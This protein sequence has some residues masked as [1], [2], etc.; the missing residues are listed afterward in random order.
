M[1]AKG[2]SLWGRPS[3]GDEGPP[4]RKVKKKLIIFLLVFVLNF[5][6][7]FMFH[8]AFFWIIF[9]GCWK[10][11]GVWYAALFWYADRSV[12]RGLGAAFLRR[13]KWYW[14]FLHSYA[15]IGFAKHLIYF[16][17]CYISRRFLQLK[18]I[19]IWLEFCIL[20]IAQRLQAAFI[21]TQCCFISIPSRAERRCSSYHYHWFAG[22]IPFIL[23][24][25]IHCSIALLK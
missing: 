4:P 9:L 13:Q 20:G 5:F 23:A 16:F 3:G 10:Y 8:Q 11:F 25:M 22:C 14:G 18:L 21:Q 12:M 19:C 7:S 1:G 24:L 6:F 17:I 15:T 2:P